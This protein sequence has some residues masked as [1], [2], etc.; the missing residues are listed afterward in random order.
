MQKGAAVDRYL[1]EAILTPYDDM[2]E[3]YFPELNLYTQGT[4]LAD[5]AY[6]A[7]DLLTMDIAERLEA[8]EDVPHIGSFGAAGAISAGSIAMGIMALVEAGC[9]RT[10]T[11]TVAEAADI[12]NVSRARIYALVKEGAIRSEKAGSS[13]LLNAQDVMDRFNSPRNPDRP[14]KH[15]DGAKSAL[16]STTMGGGNAR[17]RSEKRAGALNQPLCARQTPDMGSLDGHI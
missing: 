13:R 11:M 7:Q 16:S 6:M 15:S 4:S 9:E 2:Y 14:P 10:E 3:V 1:Y 8:G 17:D 12:L 5:A